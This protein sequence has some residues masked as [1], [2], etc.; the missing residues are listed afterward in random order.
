MQIQIYS[1][2]GQA[3]L[4]VV[5]SAF[6]RSF[7]S[8]GVQ[9]VRGNTS[10]DSLLQVYINPSDDL[11]K[12]LEDLM[13]RGGKVL[14]L[15]RFSQRIG[16]VLGLIK[17]DNGNIENIDFAE[18][19]NRTAA[20]HSR[21]LVRYLQ[22]HP[23]AK[24]AVLN[25][26][27]F[28]RFDYMDEWNN[29]GFG[30]IATDGGPW[31]VSGG[32][33]AEVATIIAAISKSDDH[34]ALTL[35]VYCAVRDYRGGSVL[36]FDRPVG[37]VDSHE[38]GIVEAFFCDYR[39]ED[40]ACIPLLSE[41]PYACAGTVTMRL[42]CDE[43]VSSA[44]SLFELYSD[45]HI[46]FSLAIKTSL[47]LSTGDV[48]LVHDVLK[49]GGALLSHSHTHLRNWGCDYTEAF[50]EAKISKEHLEK[51]FPRNQP[52]QY[53][54]SPFHTNK[55]WS[56][57]ALCDAG[58]RGV[59]TGIIN[60]RPEYLIARGGQVPFVTGELVSHSQQCML[61][62]DCYR[63]QG[64]TVDVP[65]QSFENHLRAG[66][67]FGYLDHP[68]SERY[69]YGWE[70]E[71]ER[72]GAHEALIKHIRGVE[73]VEWINEEKLLSRLLLRNRIQVQTAGDGSY[74]VTGVTPEMPGLFLKYRGKLIPL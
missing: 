49:I 36:W 7:T 40:L 26:R 39:S 38:W 47:P 31:A 37:P 11:V 59:I 64:G 27:P 54:V 69:S 50:A 70:S 63:W 25:N 34:D 74:S 28:C 13:I 71:D 73:A 41:I 58:Y 24:M 21:G 19:C 16:S 66:S 22:S 51:T 60:D 3:S 15:G 65:I 23:L 10:L 35:G 33:V 1:Y 68:F 52:L 4:D 55:S 48:D 45:Y 67:V 5:Y 42:D 9:L 14:V 6:V 2:E 12:P 18:P 8:A 61:H 56:M 43:A 46:P 17:T 53:A 44:R 57:Q 30:R 72:I 32:V 62:G 29:L 20:T